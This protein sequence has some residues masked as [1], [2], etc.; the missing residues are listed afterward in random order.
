MSQPNPKTTPL[1]GSNLPHTVFLAIIQPPDGQPLEVLCSYQPHVGGSATAAESLALD[2]VNAAHKRGAQ[3]APA[4]SEGRPN[5][6][7][8]ANL[9]RAMLHPEELGWAVT[10]EVRDMARL[11]LGRRPVE[12][13]LRGV[14]AAGHPV[15]QASR[16]IGTTSNALCSGAA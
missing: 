16:V 3:V 6:M 9:A 11:A 4:S 12:T 5:P 15:M 2:L 10:P 7:L 8:L 1:P 13:A 14:S